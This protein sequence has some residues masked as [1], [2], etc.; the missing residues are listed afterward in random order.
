MIAWSTVKRR[1]K[2]DTVGGV[3]GGQNELSPFIFNSTGLSELSR[4]VQHGKVCNALQI[5]FFFKRFTGRLTFH[6]PLRRI[7]RNSD[8]RRTRGGRFSLLLA[9]QP[10]WTFYEHP[11]IVSGSTFLR[12]QPA[13]SETNYALGFDGDTA[14]TKLTW[15]VPLLPTR[16]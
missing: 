9:G 8:I 13:R 14:V 4:R 1:H 15:P 7:R 3:G 11:G 2:G 6:S 10:V 5:F 16:L 12:Y